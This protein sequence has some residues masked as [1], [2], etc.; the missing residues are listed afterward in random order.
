LTRFFFDLAWA[1]R[2]RAGGAPV[3]A[4]ASALSVVVTLGGA[5]GEDGGDVVLVLNRRAEILDSYT[6][7]QVS[8][9]R[10]RVGTYPLSVRCYAEP[11]GRG[12]LV[13]TADAAVTILDDGSGVGAITMAGLVTSAEVAMGQE[14]PVGERRDLGF[15]ARSASGELL[16]VS[17]GSAFFAV[18]GAGDRLRIGDGGRTAEGLKP[19]PAQVTVRVDGATSLPTP[20]RVT[21]ATTVSVAPE[22]VQL[23]P[24]QARSFTASVGGGAPDTT[25]L[26]SVREGAAGGAIDA[27]GRY[28]APAGVG[29]YH[30]EAVS[31]YD[32]EK[33]AVATVAVVPPGSATVPIDWGNSG[34]IPVIVR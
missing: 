19:G 13:G 18:T 32:P 33:R 29:T 5:P 12:A 6:E 28:T 8:P 24:G 26:W 30:V 23:N 31:T 4:P 22:T 7:T 10:V 15:A 2:S 1:G 34:D 27:A 16:P 21:S 25:V 20:V 3:P 11:D 17:P 9:G 14:V